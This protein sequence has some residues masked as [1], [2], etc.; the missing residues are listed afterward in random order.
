[1]CLVD[2]NNWNDT[3]L[4]SLCLLLYFH[5]VQ[6]SRIH[7]LYSS[8][9]LVPVHGVRHFLLVLLEHR[10]ALN[11]GLLENINICGRKLASRNSL[12]E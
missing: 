6:Y 1:M 7:H 9:L 5:L 2:L 12:L 4:D 10:S 11:T 8:E 3:V